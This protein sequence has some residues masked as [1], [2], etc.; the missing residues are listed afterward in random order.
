[1]SLYIFKP[2]E[3]EAQ[4]TC[5]KCIMSLTSEVKQ[6][7]LVVLQSHLRQVYHILTLISERM[8]IPIDFPVI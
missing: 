1:M 6:G 5:D 3:A 8:I 7:M 2:P 4:P